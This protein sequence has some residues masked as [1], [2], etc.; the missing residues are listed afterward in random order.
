MEFKTPQE[1]APK[2]DIGY[3]VSLLG[4]IFGFNSPVFLPDFKNRDF[5]P[6]EFSGYEIES[7]YS[8][9]EDAPVRFGKK[10]IC[11]FWFHGG[12]Y[13]TYNEYN[14]KIE[15][16]EYPTFLMPLASIV[17]FTRD[18]VITKTPTVGGAGS[19]KEIFSNNDWSISIQGI[20]FADKERKN[21]FISVRQQMEA[22]QKF[23]NIAGG[24]RVSGR[25]FSD[26]LITCIVMESLKF[27]PVQGKPDI[28]PYTIEATSDAD[29]LMLIKP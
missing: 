10:V 11:P 1:L 29:P 26:K 13:P 6:G 15:H 21:S 23:Y 5:Q 19:V 14:G 7:D 20:I 16:P 4:D 24:I 25:I 27:N 18:K 17:S 3:A 9:E 2:L 28:M 22:I 12:K 8:Y